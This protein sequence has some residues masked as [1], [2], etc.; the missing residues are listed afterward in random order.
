MKRKGS[1]IPEPP[2]AKKFKSFASP[3]GT[4]STT[5]N[6][7]DSLTTTTTMLDH[8]ADD[9]DGFGS[10]DDASVKYTEKGMEY[11]YEYSSQEPSN[12]NTDIVPAVTTSVKTSAVT[13]TKSLVT[14]SPALTPVN[15]AM[16]AKAL[17]I[18][19]APDSKK[20]TPEKLKEID[21]HV[22]MERERVKKML[23]QKLTMN[24]EM[25][26]QFNEL[27]T[28]SHQCVVSEW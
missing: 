13:K 8:M 3:L 6:V 18:A 5:T 24:K 14:T 19:A 20:M 22:V 15:K 23:Q 9:F 17:P 4:I 27:Q 1:T 10:L 21:A 12:S 16:P 26:T 7:V 11:E 28:L 25:Y 2:V